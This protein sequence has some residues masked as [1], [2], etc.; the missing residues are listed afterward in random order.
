[1]ARLLVDNDVLLKAAHWGLLDYIPA[2]TG[3]DWESTSV[4]ESLLH[5]TRRK[6]TK[7]FRD[8]AI[9]DAL[10]ARLDRTVPMPAPDPAIIS[11]L[12][13][14][15]GIDAGEVTLF[16]ALCACGDAALLTGDKRAL[17][18]MAAPELADVAAQLRGRVICLEHLLDHA[19]DETGATALAELIAPHRD[20]DTAVRC[21]VP[22]P[23]HAQE[24]SI[25]EGLT[26]YLNELQCE[27]SGI[28]CVVMPRSS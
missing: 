25:R 7:L 9:A 21:I 1:M 6:D 13:G 22:M 3:V 24:Y 5:R 27:T 20:L 12:Q 10:Q 26:S 19:L 4:L 28:V 2:C 15:I 11:R 23:D 17:R 8:P 14:H 16:A 18:A